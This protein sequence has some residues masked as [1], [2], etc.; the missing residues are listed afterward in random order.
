M[1]S[2]LHRP[3]GD[4]DD[5]LR[6]SI[7]AAAR[8]AASGSARASGVNKSAVAFGQIETPKFSFLSK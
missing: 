1:G 3:C 5:R 6:L 2:R 7:A 4:G 8:I